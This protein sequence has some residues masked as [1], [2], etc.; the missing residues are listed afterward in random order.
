MGKNSNSSST[1]EKSPLSQRNNFM[2][3]QN[4]V[5]NGQKHNPGPAQNKNLINTAPGPVPLMTLED[6][7]P[8]GSDLPKAQQYEILQ[9]TNMLLSGSHPSRNVPVQTRQ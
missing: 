3:D 2:R 9:R 8:D 6:L 7:F 4:N 1:S 5:L